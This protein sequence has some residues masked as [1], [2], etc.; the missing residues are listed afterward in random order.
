MIKLTQIFDQ[1]Y[2]IFGHVKS[3]FSA[4]YGYFGMAF[5]SIFGFLQ[6]DWLPFVVLFVLIIFDLILGIAVSIKFGTFFTSKLGLNT[7]IKIALYAIILVS[8][9]LLEV[10]IHESGLIGLKV[11]AFIAGACEIWSMTANALILKPNMPFIRLLR[12]QLK[13]EIE[14]KVGKNCDEILKDG[15]TTHKK[16]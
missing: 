3:V 14:N 16:T 9:G 15:H 11:A 5:C 12:L 4:A 7:L 6:T 1:F 10:L 8:I 2:N 13:S